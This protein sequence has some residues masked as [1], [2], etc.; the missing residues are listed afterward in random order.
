MLIFRI[1]N[2]LR[3]TIC[4]VFGCVNSKDLKYGFHNLY[5]PFVEEGNIYRIIIMIDSRPA[6]MKE[7]NILLKNNR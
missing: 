7:N 6:S 5:I 3:K 4:Y 1:Y 2:N